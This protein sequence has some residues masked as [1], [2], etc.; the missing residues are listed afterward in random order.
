MYNCNAIWSRNCQYV[1]IFKHI[2]GHAIVQELQ[3][4]DNCKNNETHVP[5]T[6]RCYLDDPWGMLASKFIDWNGGTVDPMEN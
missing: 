2:V 1:E 4:N 5:G 3:M 6:W